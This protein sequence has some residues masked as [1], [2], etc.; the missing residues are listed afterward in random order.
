[1]FTCFLIGSYSDLVNIAMSDGS[2]F[3][4]S[5]TIGYEGEGFTVEPEIMTLLLGDAGATFR[6]GA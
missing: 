6:V 4:N 3:S 2:K 1:M 5:Y